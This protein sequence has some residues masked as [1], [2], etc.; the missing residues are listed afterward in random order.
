MPP[1]AYGQ[2]GQAAEQANLSPLSF[3]LS[4]SSSLPLL[5]KLSLLSLLR[6]LLSV[7]CQLNP[8]SSYSFPS[9]RHSNSVKPRVSVLL[10]SRLY[11]SSLPRSSVF[12]LSAHSLRDFS[13][14]RTLIF[15]FFF[16][17]C[18]NCIKLGPLLLPEPRSR[19]QLPLRYISRFSSTSVYFAFVSRNPFRLLF[20]IIFRALPAL[21]SSSCTLIA[22]FQ[23]DSVFKSRFY[24]DVSSTDF[25]VFPSVRVRRTSDSSLIIIPH[26]TDATTKRTSR[27]TFL[28]F[29]FARREGTCERSMAFNVRRA[30]LIM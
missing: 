21:S 5:V 11:F 4:L 16:A 24:L 12:L 23:C 10:S 19:P 25:S 15:S 26:K 3:P 14:Y 2:A 17:F 20:F 29:L 8:S 9:P 18:F 22:R 28:N 6:F 27:S 30:F 7:S 13:R 1:T